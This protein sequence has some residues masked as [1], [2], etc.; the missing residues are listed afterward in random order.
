M[1]TDSRSGRAGWQAARDLHRRPIALVALL[2]ALVW[3]LGFGLVATQGYEPGGGDPRDYVLLAENLRA[4]NGYV[5]PWSEGESMVLRPTALRPPLYPLLLSG[6]FSAAGRSI[7]AV[8]VVQAVVDTLS[9]ALLGGIAASLFGPHAGVAA[10]WW[11]ALH[12]SLWVHVARIW[13][14]CLFIALGVCL[15]FVLTTRGRESW[16]GTSW[17]AGVLLGLLCLTRP[18]GIFF[19]PVVALSIGSAAS[20]RERLKAGLVV[21]FAMGL[22]LSPW[23]LRNYR[24]FERFIPLSTMDA[25]VIRGAYNDEVVTDAWVRGAWSLN[26]LIAESKGSSDEIELRDRFLR[27][28]REWIRRHWRELPGLFARRLMRFWGSEWYRSEIPFLGRMPWLEGLN[29]A[30]YL[31]TVAFAVAG[32]WAHRRRIGEL[33]V[34]LL[35]PVCFSVSAALTWGDWRIRAP[36]EPVLVLL[37]AACFPL[38]RRRDA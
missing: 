20:S 34:L 4:G 37:A 7:P 12:P 26:T 31:V 25:V 38:R 28:S 21:V 19:L 29:R 9:C 3:R 24:C 33:G 23:T 11:A 17:R 2:G 15:L 32:A 10:L 35:V 8:V 5:L 36:V 16:L 6:I 30:S 1:G 14:E 13:S 18:N 22:V 27:D